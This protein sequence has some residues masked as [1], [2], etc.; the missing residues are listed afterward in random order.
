MKGPGKWG[1]ERAP[2]PGLG[3]GVLLS[4]QAPGVVALLLRIYYFVFIYVGFHLAGFTV[5]FRLTWNSLCVFV[6]QAGLDL[7]RTFLPQPQYCWEQGFATRAG[8][9]LY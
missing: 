8:S 6:S 2:A 3:Q 5:L 1:K 4:V 9:I 7:S